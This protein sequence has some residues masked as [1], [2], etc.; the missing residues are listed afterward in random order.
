M[1]KI[2]TDTTTSIKY[3]EDGEPLG[4]GALQVH[5]CDNV[6]LNGTL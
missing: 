1:L 3:R 6:E 4:R 5:Y 2:Y